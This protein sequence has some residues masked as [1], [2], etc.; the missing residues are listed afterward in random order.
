[1]ACINVSECQPGPCLGSFWEKGGALAFLDRPCFYAALL[2]HKDGHD[3]PFFCL[4]AGPT[5]LP[6]LARSSAHH[7]HLMSHLACEAHN[8]ISSVRHVSPHL[9]LSMFY[10]VC[11]THLVCIACLTSPA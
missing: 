4:G 11:V 6:S 9:R 1:M 3:D 7:L 10:L 8:V 5:K 2:L